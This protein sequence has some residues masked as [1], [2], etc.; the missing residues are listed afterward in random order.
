MVPRQK[1]ELRHGFDGMGQRIVPERRHAGEDR[2]TERKELYVSEMQN[3]LF[4]P[5]AALDQWLAD[6]AI[7]LQ[8]TELSIL[9]EARRY[10]LAEAARVKSEVTGAADGNELVGR[11]KSKQ[12][13]EELG[14]ELLE[15]SMIL[16]ENAYDVMPGWLAYPIGSF[17][18]FVVSAERAKARQQS[19]FPAD[20]PR[21]EE[22]LLARYLLKNL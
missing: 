7:E 15:N 14:A 11:V 5:Q 10:R 19:S 3:R 6:G 17:E 18:E 1:A 16:G 2:A 8:G 21:T 22:D 4:F 12:Y 20:E 13:L 9:A